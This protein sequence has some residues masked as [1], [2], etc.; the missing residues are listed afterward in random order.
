VELTD[1]FSIAVEGPI[2]VGKA[3]LAKALAER[4]G[5]TAVIEEPDANAFLEDFYLDTERWAL[6]TQIGF[7][8]ARHRTLYKLAAHGWGDR[9]VTDFLFAKHEIYARA[10]LAGRELALYE[11]LTN[12]LALPAPTPDLVIVLQASTDV[13]CDR[14]LARRRPSERGITRSYLEAL[15]E[16]YTRFFFHYSESSVLVVNTNEID[17]VADSATMDALLSR[18]TEHPGGTLYYSPVGGPGDAG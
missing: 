5:A 18:I 4:L 14:V 16:A 6:A 10:T 8:L 13:L 15:N 7:F 2:G 1:R 17:P 3:P 11:E 12:A 9:T